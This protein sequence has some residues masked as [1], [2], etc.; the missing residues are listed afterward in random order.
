MCHD[1]EKRVNGHNIVGDSHAPIY[2][3]TS[4]LRPL[5]CVAMNCVILCKD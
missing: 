1:I 3:M 5:N 2:N 4:E